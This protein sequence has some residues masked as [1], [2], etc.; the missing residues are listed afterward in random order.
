MKT[1][2]AALFVVGALATTSVQAAP[3]NGLPAWA[4]QALTPSS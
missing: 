4:Q 1:L 3:S 2:I